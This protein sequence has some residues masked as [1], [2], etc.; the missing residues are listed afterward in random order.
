MHLISGG[1]TGGSKVH[2][3]NLLS[4]FPRSQTTLSVM[5]TGPLY[6]E[7]RDK[8]LNVL[9]LNQRSRYDLS[10]LKKLIHTLKDGNY[11]LLHTHGPRANVYGALA[12][13]SIQIPW[14]STIHSD[15][16]LDFIQGGLKGK[17][18]TRMNL[19]A[20]NKI[21]HFFAVSS[22]FKQHLIQL[23]ISEEKITV[24]YNGIDFS[25][26]ITMRKV[27]TARK[28]F[29]LTDED[30]VMT[31]A[32]RLH[33]I[34][35][36]VSVFEAMQKLGDPTVHLL[37]AGDGPERSTLEKRAANLGLSRQVHF[38]G[39]R[40]D[41]ADLYRTS[42]VGLLASLSESFPFALLEAAREKTPVIATDVGD[43]AL[44]LDNYGWVVPVKDSNALKEAIS[45]A[46][47][48]K[49]SGELDALGERFHDHVR[50]HFSLEQLAHSVKTTYETI[51][52][53]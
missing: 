12:K 51:V 25:R 22:R 2:M 26:D 45:E 20:L 28:S 41:V 38:L 32:A 4:R 37:L 35:G 9:S 47:Q 16:R 15:P 1:E 24:I 34:K 13:R 33:P 40:N 46:K 27:G 36:H 52:G 42:D 48:K 5:E 18:F 14:L 31:M 29:G 53:R 8:Q 7:A 50:R 23:G 30:F 17:M 6:E 21:D 10:A 19:W 49:K 44:M 3:I 43:V 39:Y 11:D